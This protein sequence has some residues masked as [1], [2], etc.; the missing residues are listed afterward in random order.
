MKKIINRI[1]AVVILTVCA[2][3]AMAQSQS[4]VEALR[5]FVKYYSA[6]VDKNTMKNALI[7]ANTALYPKLSAE[8]SE[9]LANRY[10]ETRLMEDMLKIMAKSHSKYITEAEV[11]EL[12]AKLKTP[13]GIQATAHGKDL[14]AKVSTLVETMQPNIAAAVRGETI[15]YAKPI[16]TTQEYKRAW[17]KYYVFA[18][19]DKIAEKSFDTMASVQPANIRA[20]LAP[21]RAYMIKDMPTLIFN[22]SY[23]CFVLADLNFYNNMYESTA[24]KHLKEAENHW[25]DNMMSVGYEIITKYQVWSSVQK[26]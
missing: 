26:K 18:G 15:S 7:Q 5:E 6:G 12:T 22:E 10:V 11:R 24:G 8:K 23:K 17:D 16:V 25:V 9:Q 20:S 1:L 21:V 19:F 4:Y 14:S 2:S 13:A 3:S